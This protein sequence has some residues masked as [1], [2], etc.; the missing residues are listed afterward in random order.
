MG[1]MRFLPSAG[2]EELVKSPVKRVLGWFNRPIAK[3]RFRR[4]VARADKL[5]LHLGAATFRLPGWINT[6]AYWRASHY[7]DVTRPW[8]VAPESVSYVYADNVIEHLTLA[9]GRRMLMH[10]FRSLHDGGRI[11][12]STPDVERMARIYLDDPEAAGELLEW[13]Q[14][15]GRDAAHPVDLLRI[16]FTHWGHETGYLYDFASLAE[17]LIRAGF[18]RVSRWST[19]ESADPVL[20]NLEARTDAE[21]SIQLVVEAERPIPTVH[22]RPYASAHSGERP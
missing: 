19:G 9:E 4:A 21:A 7:L 13:H 6:D 5:R 17:E 18:G 22:D 14:G 12:L 16:Y 3:L 8:P 20:R 11:R 10:A 2:C 15:S 1:G